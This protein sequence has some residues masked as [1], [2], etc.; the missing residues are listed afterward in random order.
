VK[1]GTLVDT[2]FRSQSAPEIVGIDFFKTIAGLPM[3][4]RVRDY[5][6]AFTGDNYILVQYRNKTLEVLDHSTDYLITLN[7][8]KI[9]N[10]K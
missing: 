1:F 2:D 8:L 3:R 7:E 9:P 4:T 10:V 6:L 5:N